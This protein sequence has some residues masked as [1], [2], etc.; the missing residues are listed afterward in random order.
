MLELATDVS[1]VDQT[2]LFL[3]NLTNHEH[4]QIDI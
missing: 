1:M 2:K 3:Y 4:D